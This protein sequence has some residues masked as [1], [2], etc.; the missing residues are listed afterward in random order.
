MDR[1]K[2]RQKIGKYRYRQKD[3]Y[4]D[5]DIYYI[6]SDIYVYRQIDRIDILNEER[7]SNEILNKWFVSHYYRI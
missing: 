5:L 1:Q 2:D 6:D 7:V 4:I 3:R